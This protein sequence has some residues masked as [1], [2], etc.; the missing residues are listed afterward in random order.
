MADQRSIRPANGP[1][2]AEVTSLPADDVSRRLYR[3]YERMRA[4]LARLRK[5]VQRLSVRIGLLHG[6]EEAEL[7]RPGMSVEATV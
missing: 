1:V 3:D 5:D 4:E 2:D 6:Q 7:L